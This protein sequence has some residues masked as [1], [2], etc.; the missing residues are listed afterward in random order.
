MKRW[1]KRQRRHRAQLPDVTVVLRSAWWAS[2]VAS[3]DLYTVIAYATSFV[4]GM[5]IG[6]ERQWRQRSAV[7]VPTR[8]LR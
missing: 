6:F 4:R 2:F 8:W 3:A 1:S 5:L 7:C